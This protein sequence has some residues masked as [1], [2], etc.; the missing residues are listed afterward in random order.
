MGDNTGREVFITDKTK[1]VLIVSIAFLLVLFF[2]G[3]V[4]QVPLS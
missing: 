4:F 1:Q 2:L 3:Y